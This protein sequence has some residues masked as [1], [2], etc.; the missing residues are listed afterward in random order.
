MEKATHGPMSPNHIH[1]S[2]PASLM[3]EGINKRILVSHMS[4]HKWLRNFAKQ[5]LMDHFTNMKWYILRHSHHYQF[6][7]HGFSIQSWMMPQ[8]S[9]YSSARPPSG[10]HARFPS[11]WGS[12]PLAAHRWVCL[13]GMA[14]AE[15]GCFTQASLTSWGYSS[16][17]VLVQ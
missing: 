12:C 3:L 16:N 17:A 15:G 6:S 2:Q 7:K 10:P 5:D 14:S 1:S 9:L 8:G 13:Q 11:C 4:Q